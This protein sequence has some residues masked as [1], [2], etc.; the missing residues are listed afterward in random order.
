MP[1]IPRIVITGAGVEHLQM[2]FAE[3]KYDYGKE[4]IFL[5]KGGKTVKKKEKEVVRYIHEFSMS[6][7]IYPDERQIGDQEI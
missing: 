2:N 3:K 6:C 5:T 1:N 7:N 4:L